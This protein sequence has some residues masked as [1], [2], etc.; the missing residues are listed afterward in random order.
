MPA[1]GRRAVLG[2]TLGA[3][4]TPAAAQTT[5]GAAPSR[6]V[7]LGTKGGPRVMPIGARGMAANVVIAG[8][9]PYV[10]DCGYGVT[11][12]L[13]TL[14]IPLA[15]LRHIFVTHHHSDHVIEYPN[16]FLLAWASGLASRVD[17]WGPPP[18]EDVTRLAFAMNATD[19]AVRMD[20]EG[21]PD[22][23]ALVFAHDL[24]LPGAVMQD[25][26]VRVTC[27][28][29]DHG[30]IRP[31]YAYRFEMADRTVVFSGDTTYYPPLAE[32]ARGADVLIHEVMYLPAMDRLLAANP[33]APTLRG[34]LIAGH[35][36]PE[37]VGRIAAA[38]NVGKLVL[39][40][41]VPGDR[42]D[43]PDH[44]WIAGVRTT[45]DGEVVVA[46]DMMEV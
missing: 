26:H 30:P 25:A 37:D 9:V 40:H 3:L 46:R 14:G 13:A 16:L 43:I 32:F 17:C 12:K 28:T 8:G 6:V 35:T 22:P 11:E 10:V 34:H 23:R 18:I 45:F 19:I 2:G 1:P 38:A 29:V 7:I 39:T 42:P 33:N 20:E 27:A 44:V 21:R 41:L 5:A 4:A 15:K 31:A 36:V 24:P